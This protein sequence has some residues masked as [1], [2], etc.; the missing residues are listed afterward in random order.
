MYRPYNSGWRQYIDYNIGVVVEILCG[1]HETV[2]SGMNSMKWDYGSKRNISNL[3]EN[4]NFF[5]KRTP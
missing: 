4:V 5:I 3:V 1:V 2:M